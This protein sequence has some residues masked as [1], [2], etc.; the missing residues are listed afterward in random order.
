MGNK[1]LTSPMAAVVTEI[2]VKNG[3]IVRQGQELIIIE[4]MKM[5]NAICAQHDGKITSIHVIAGDAIIKDQT[6]ISYDK[7]NE[8]ILMDSAQKESIATGHH[9]QEL[10][11]RTE[12]LKDENRPKAVEKRKSRGQNMARE[13]LE[14]LIDKDSFKEY[15]SLV[16]A[17][18]RTRRTVEDLIE[19]T[20]A[21]GLVM[22]T[23]SI[24]QSVLPSADC[25]C[26]VMI[27]DY[28]VLAG[29]QGTMN[30]L[31]MDRMLH[32]AQKNQL[33]VI[34]FAEG[35]GGR[36]GDVD[37]QT[38]A[39]LHI[40]TFVEFGRLS[41]LVPV[42]AVVSGYCFAG[43]AALAGIAD[44]IIATENSSIGMGGPAMIEGGGLGNCHPKEVGPSEIHVE[45][46]VID[47]LVKNEDE[48]IIKAKQYLSYFQGNV[49]NYKCADQSQLRE[50]IPENRKR[51]Y[52]IRSI[53]SLIAD[54]ETM[55]ELR[56]Q[57]GKGLI[58][59]FI[60]IE[61]IAYGLIANNPAHEAGALN[62]ENAIKANAFMELCNNHGL[63]MISLVDTPGIMVGPEAEKSGTVRHASK[64]FI[65]GA[66]LRVPFY[67]V[68]LRR[69]YGLGAMAMVGGSTH[70]PDFVVAWPT[71]EFG[72][73][74][75]EG[76]VKLGFRKELEAISDPQER[77]T[78]YN[79]MVEVAYERGKAIS[80]A[81]M[82]EIDNVIDPIDT[83]SWISSAY[84]TRKSKK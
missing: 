47:V 33:A 43:N 78:E 10:N 40:S 3:D 45:N 17:A 51:T 23:A 24:N 83:R 9:L 20:P 58:T 53:I 39:G 61:G 65:T 64:L 32:I 59:C 31:K 46:G 19:N 84:K 11:N 48:A 44:V 12:Y 71:G 16:I 82:F 56:P 13:N 8:Q 5:E 37:Q 7:A 34:L 22:G 1:K 72:A 36:P 6:L 75:L 73:M 42:V 52:D 30:H 15:G 62:S 50:A 66:K 35:G 41:G 14:K 77:E 26:V 38:I 70:V 28:S 79:R 49:E 67:A 25:Q 81:S 69:A 80:M 63:P 60:R 21:D 4:A 57:Y 29:T 55:L 68:V 54:E 27:Y 74:G 76:A 2:L 18:Q